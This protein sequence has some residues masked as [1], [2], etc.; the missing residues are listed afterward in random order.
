[1]RPPTSDESPGGTV[2]DY[3]TGQA[4][5]PGRT[6]CACRSAPM[7]SLRP[8]QDLLGIGPHEGTM[9][10]HV[11]SPPWARF[12]NDH[13]FDRSNICPSLPVARGNKSSTGAQIG[14]HLGAAS[15]GLIPGSYVC[16]NPA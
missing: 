7:F 10:A 6:S 5:R 4:P 14:V 2:V 3:P 13:L 16:G 9:Q 12:P 15:W 1:M 8:T 11:A